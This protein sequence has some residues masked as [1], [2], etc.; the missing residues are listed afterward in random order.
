M[1]YIFLSKCNCLKVTSSKPNIKDRFYKAQDINNAVDGAKNK[2][3]EQLSNP[4][5]IVKVF[6]TIDE[7][8]RCNE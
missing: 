3:K 6:N 7:W 4:D 1:V 2:I 5:D 8:L